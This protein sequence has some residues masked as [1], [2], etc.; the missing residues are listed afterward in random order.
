MKKDSNNTG[1]R[2]EE[3]LSIAFHNGIVLAHFNKVAHID[4]AH[5]GAVWNTRSEAYCWFIALHCCETG[6]FRASTK[7]KCLGLGV[8]RALGGIGLAG[9]GVTVSRFG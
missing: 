1:G 6:P 5:P 8:A 7:N 3:G 4:A 9:T 2:R